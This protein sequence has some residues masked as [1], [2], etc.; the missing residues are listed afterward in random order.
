MA[1]VFEF[2][3]GFMDGRQVSSEAEDPTE[4]N[5]I[6]SYYFMTDNGT[7]GKRF[8]TISDAAMQSLMTEGLEVARARGFRMNHKYE[9][10][11]KIDREGD[12]VVRVTF[13]GQED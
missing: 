4:A 12:V 5:C 3:G 7:V 8:K 6:G 11:E 10:V 9:V 2:T 13:V 1:I